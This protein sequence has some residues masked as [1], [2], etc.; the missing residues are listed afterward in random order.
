M[1]AAPA[2]VDRDGPLATRPPHPCGDGE[3]LWAAD[4]RVRYG[5]S[6]RRAL[7]IMREAGA[8]RP[9]L[10]LMV[11]LDALRR[12]EAR[13]APA[14]AASLPAPAAPPRAATG[15]RTPRP[16]GSDLDPRAYGWWREARQ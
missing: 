5:C 10:A 14:A 7:A 2:V 16:S 4:V 3:H 6:R 12:W 1:T 11:R 13:Q 15:P 9:G 8:F